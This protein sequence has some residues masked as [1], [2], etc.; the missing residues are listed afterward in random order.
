M[1]TRMALLGGEASDRTMLAAAL[2]QELV[3][4]APGV[5]VVFDDTPALAAQGRDDLTLLLAPD[6]TD[7][8]HGEA[9]DAMLREALERAGIAFQIVHGQGNARVQQALRAIGHAMG[10]SLVVADPA[11][12]VGRGQW[13][14]E[15]CS[16]PECER[17]LFSQLLSREDLAPPRFQAKRE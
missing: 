13:S 14:C 16:D 3:L 10:R 1:A 6:P 2:H 4:H 5:D 9:A 8:P 11:L 12:S 15:N 17:R 7:G